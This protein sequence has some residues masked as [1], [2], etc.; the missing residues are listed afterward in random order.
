MRFYASMEDA[1]R[2]FEPYAVLEPELWS[3]WDL[4]CRAA[5]P[6]RPE[7]PRNDGYDFFDPFEID[8]LAV[9]KPEEG[10][11]AED[12]FRQHV[13]SR[14]VDLVGIDRR[15]EPHHLETHESYDIVHDLLINWARSTVRL[16][17]RSRSR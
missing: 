16:L 15:R 3:L 11:C 1:R 2:A 14:L 7:P 4:C 17:R 13:K 8:P 12:Y 9:D 6:P 5:P 10:W